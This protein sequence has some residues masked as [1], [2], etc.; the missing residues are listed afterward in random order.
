[1]A[2]SQLLSI[3]RVWAA[4]A[5]ADGVLAP[6]EADGLR[7]LIKT[8]ELTDAER[9]DAFIF[10]DYKVELPARYLAELPPDVRRGVYRA[11]CQLATLDHIFAATERAMLDRLCWVLELSADDARAIEAEVPGVIAAP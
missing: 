5:W 11:A 7:A 9:H 6:S 4:V 10:L 1:M 2:E 8:A 3:I